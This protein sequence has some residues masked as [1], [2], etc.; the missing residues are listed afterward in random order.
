[1]PGSLKPNTMAKSTKPKCQICNHRYAIKEVHWNDDGFF[2][3][4]GNDKCA[5]QLQKGLSENWKYQEFKT[6]IEHN[7]DDYQGR[8]YEKI[9]DKEKMM[10]YAA[11][12]LGIIV[13]GTILYQAFFYFLNL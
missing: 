12:A 9:A 1:V 7:P 5:K 3:V 13:I 10:Q 6:R 11:T 2:L 8:S 4:C